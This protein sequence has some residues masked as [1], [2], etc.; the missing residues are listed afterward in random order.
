[1][2]LP[3]FEDIKSFI[4]GLCESN[5]SIATE[6]IGECDEIMVTLDRSVNQSTNITEDPTKNLHS[7]ILSDLGNQTPCL[8]SLTASRTTSITTPNH[9][10]TSNSISLHHLLDGVLT[11]MTKMTVPQA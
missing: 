6:I 5:M 2:S 4:F 7:P 8:L 9:C 10:D 11:D 1:M 3:D